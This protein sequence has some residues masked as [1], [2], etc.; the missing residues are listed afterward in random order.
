ML[1]N[2]WQGGV[3]WENV[4]KDIL[5]GEQSI[6]IAEYAEDR[7]PMEIDGMTYDL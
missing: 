6:R 2:V 7:K 5:S 1:H 3:R 4:N